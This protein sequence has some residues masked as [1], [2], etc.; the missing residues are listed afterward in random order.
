MFLDFLQYGHKSSEQIGFA[1]VRILLTKVKKEK[2]R[3]GRILALLNFCIQWLFWPPKIARPFRS[4][5]PSLEIILNLLLVK[6]N[7]PTCTVRSRYLHFV[8]TFPRGAFAQRIK[9]LTAKSFRMCLNDDFLIDN[10]SV[11][12]LDSRQSPHKEFTGYQKSKDGKNISPS[13]TLR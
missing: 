13:K 5:N 10:W 11:I 4:V 3:H 12:S 7:Y 9:S 8:R 6:T 1:C 2:Q